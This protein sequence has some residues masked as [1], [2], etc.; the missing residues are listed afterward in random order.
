MDLFILFKLFFCVLVFFYAYRSNISL[1]T[2]IVVMTIVI[3]SI[4]IGE[5]Q[6]CSEQPV[7]KI[8]GYEDN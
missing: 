6:I 4:H 2:F 5:D 1:D 3:C 8:Y 7:Q